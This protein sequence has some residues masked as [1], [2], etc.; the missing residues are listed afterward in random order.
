[1][2]FDQTVEDLYEDLTKKVSDDKYPDC[3]ILEIYWKD[4]DYCL[5][6]LHR[7]VSDELAE[8]ILEE[9]RTVEI[10]SYFAREK[11]RTQKLYSSIKDFLDR[12][13]CI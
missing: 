11:D 13:K 9:H 7:W 10:V 4:K 3:S 6:V 5:S 12:K 8:F 2:G 1:M